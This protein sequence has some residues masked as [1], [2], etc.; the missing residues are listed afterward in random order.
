MYGSQ[1]ILNNVSLNAY[2]GVP[3]IRSAGYKSALLGMEVDR[4]RQRLL[5]S[6]SVLVDGCFVTLLR[7]VLNESEVSVLITELPFLCDNPLNVRKSPSK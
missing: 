2:V 1:L 6:S 5:H 7:L 3:V 4:F